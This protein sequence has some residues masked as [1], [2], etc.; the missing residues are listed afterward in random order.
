MSSV[1]TAYT[2]AHGHPLAHDGLV[3]RQQR[4]RRWAVGIRAAVVAA[5]ALALVVGVIV[6][7]DLARTS[8]APV[9]LAE[10]D[11]A[12]A[13]SAGESGEGAGE[14]GASAPSDPSSPAGAES[15][16]GAGEASA[17]AP[18]APASVAVHVVGQVTSP[19]VVEVA[20]G[21][22]VID[23][24]T[25]AG[26][27][28]ETADA[29]AVNLARPVVDGEQIYV[30]VPGEVIPAQAAGPATGSTPGAPAPGTA[31]GTSGSGAAINLNTA[32]AAALDTLPGI[33]PAIAGRIIDWREAHGGFAAVDDLLEVSGIGPAVLTSIRDLVTV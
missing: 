28:T 25:A 16:L 15:P 2:A 19:G 29:G 5:L 20:A 31:A 11:P 23:A 18:A 7:R 13:T 10:V 26:G 32:D 24:I 33:G 8:G 9:P 17:R 30:P 6:V 3:A 12:A 22:R 4:R 27:L 1:S 21:A 14:P